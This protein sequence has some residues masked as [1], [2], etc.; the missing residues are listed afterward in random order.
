MKMDVLYFI[1]KFKLG[2]V[3]DPFFFLITVFFIDGAEYL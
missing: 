3:A 1:L 2:M